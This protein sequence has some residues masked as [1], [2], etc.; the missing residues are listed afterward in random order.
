MTGDHEMTA[1]PLRNLTFSTTLACNQRCSHCWVAAGLRRENELGFTEIA[2]VLE[3]ARRLG[4]EH[5]KL[6][7]G[8]PFSRP[9]AVDVVLTAINL[10]LRVSVE[11]NGMGVPPR[12]LDSVDSVRDHLTFYI[13][14]D[15]PSSDIHD[16]LRGIAGAFH[17]TMATMRTLARLGLRFS[18]HTVVSRANYAHIRETYKVVQELG[19]LQHKLIFD[20]H[21]LGRGANVQQ[22]AIGVRDVFVLLEQLPAAHFWDYDWR[23]PATTTTVLMSTLPPAFQPEGSEITTCGWGKSFAAILANGDVAIC[24]GLY[25]EEAARAGNVRSSSLSDIWS[26]SALFLDSRKWDQEQM[27]GIC[28]NC[29]VFQHCRGL[30]RASAVAHFGDLKAPYPFCQHAYE[31]GVFP[32]SMMHDPDRDCSYGEPPSPVASIRDEAG[33][34]HGASVPVPVALSAA[35]HHKKRT[36]H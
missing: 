12:L 9:D 8:E 19:A 3:Q 14:L 11:T 30:C 23:P 24:H 36:A 17:K 5:V 33:V 6:T 10:G 18:V 21:P 4:A 26:E 31:L 29:R 34:E 2:N 1:P 25:D 27:L 22:D 15:G 13:S 20:I 32:K 16:P 28:R 7:G 35:R